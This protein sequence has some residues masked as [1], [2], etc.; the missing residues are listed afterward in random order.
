MSKEAHIIADPACSGH[1]LWTAAPGGIERGRRRAGLR[2]WPREPSVAG[3]SQRPH[4]RVSHRSD[5]PR[6]IEAVAK[7]KCVG[8]F[9]CLCVGIPPNPTSLLH[10]GCNSSQ[11]CPMFSTDKMIEPIVHSLLGGL[12]R[13]FATLDSGTAQQ[14]D[15]RVSA[16]RECCVV[17]GPWPP[18]LRC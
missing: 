14:R 15:I 1:H 9:V 5:K 16:G 8:Q 2:S 7:L 17:E 13:N 10:G 6:H 18:V 11:N 4:P 3:S 12:R